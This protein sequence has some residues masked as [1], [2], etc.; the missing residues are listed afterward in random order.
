MVSSPSWYAAC[1]ARSAS[2]TGRAPRSACSTHAES[3]YSDR[4]RVQVLLLDADGQTTQLGSEPAVVRSGQVVLSITGAGTDLVRL[5]GRPVRLS[6][7]PTGFLA[8]DLTRSTGFHRLDL[9]GSTFWF[10]TEDAKL[11]LAGVEAMLRELGRSIPP[12]GGQIMFS[13]G[14]LLRD[15]GVVYGWL[16]EWADSVLKAIDRVWQMPAYAP[17]REYRVSRRGGPGIDVRK[18]HRHLRS[19]PQ[20]RLEKS[21]TGLLQLGDERYSPSSVVVRS[22]GTSVVSIPNQRVAK[23]LSVI[24]DLVREVQHSGPTGAAAIRC[25]EWLRRATA[26]N[27]ASIAGEIRRAGVPASA[28]ASPRQ[29]VE[30]GDDRYRCCY[31]AARDLVDGMGWSPTRV[32]MSRYSY[33][34]YSDEIYQAYVAA[35]IAAALGLQLASPVLG[36]EQ[37][38]FVGERLDLYYDTELPWEVLRSWRWS[39]SAPDALRPD[40]VVHERSSGR[41]AVLDAKYRA[42]GGGATEDSRKEVLSYMAA[43]GIPVAG[44]LF[45]GSELGPV[46]ERVTGA[47]NRLLEI[48]VSPESQPDQAELREVVQESL[49]WS[50]Y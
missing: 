7:A 35:V 25:A 50:R 37:P 39:S 40:V 9:L 36:K 2:V 20:E 24:S 1:S 48:S 45:P 13:E 31:Q 3:A 16:E 41:V 15:S 6:G 42:T 26:L 49:C 43:F 10:G 29:A 44:I 46:V 33:A 14:G 28:L 19:R 12:W 34:S 18:T 30:V 21:A 38:A 32:P 5:D 47:T 17:T 27:S 11:G 4:G 8:V 22:R 23:L